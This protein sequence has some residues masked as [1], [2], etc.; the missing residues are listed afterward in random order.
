MLC[1]EEAGALRHLR[2]RVEC[3]GKRFGQRFWYFRIYTYDTY[4]FKS[5]FSIIDKMLIKNQ[6]SSKW[7]RFYLNKIHSIVQSLYM[8]IAGEVSAL[9][10][11]VW[12][13]IFYAQLCFCH[14][15]TC[16][17][18]KSALQEDICKHSVRC[19]WG[20][21]YFGLTLPP[22]ILLWLWDIYFQFTS[23]LPFVW[24]DCAFFPIKFFIT[25]LPFIYF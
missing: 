17:P 14:K 18:Y 2:E 9:G 10:N 12:N 23:N 1:R 7:S 22:E 11:T 20:C 24:Q 13:N 19:T 16:K 4:V 6:I 3:I 15:Y 21:V 25:T 8:W 5:F